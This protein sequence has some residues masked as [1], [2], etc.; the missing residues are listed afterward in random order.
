MTREEFLNELLEVFQRED[1]LDLDMPLKD[2]DEWDSL[3]I[4]ATMA[5][6]R[7]EFGIQSTLKDYQSMHSV[8]DIAKL[9]GI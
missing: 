1:P 7:K 4:M 9:A 2:I 8:E 6:L 3:S 5:F